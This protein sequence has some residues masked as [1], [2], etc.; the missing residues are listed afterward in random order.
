MAS[1]YL[2]LH[3]VGWSR[4]AVAFM[5]L[6]ET[7][8]VYFVCY[9]LS[10]DCFFPLTKQGIHKP[11]I[12]SLFYTFPTRVLWEFVLPT[13]HW[14]QISSGDERGSVPTELHSPGSPYCRSPLACE[15]CDC[16]CGCMRARER[17]WERDRGREGERWQPNKTQGSRTSRITSIL[18]LFLS[19][20][21]SSN[22]PFSNP[23]HEER[24]THSSLRW[25]YLDGPCLIRTITYSSFTNT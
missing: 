23:F 5:T 9:L 1:T 8:M 2:I 18:L 16:H 3:F 15:W 4:T 10:L 11:S 24:Q 21:P 7:F 17:Q 12:G 13:P 19:R 6:R 25:E 20:F 14:G 22:I